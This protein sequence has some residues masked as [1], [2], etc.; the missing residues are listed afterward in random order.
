MIDANEKVSLSQRHEGKEQLT[1]VLTD[2]SSQ[3]FYITYIYPRNSGS[4][5]LVENCY[6]YFTDQKKDDLLALFTTI[7]SLTFPEIL[8]SLIKYT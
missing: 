8:N 1:V 2:I 6:N 7:R 5:T 4:N 3:Y